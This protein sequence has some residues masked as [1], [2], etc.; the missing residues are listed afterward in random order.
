MV[1]AAALAFARRRGRAG[2]QAQGAP[3]RL[4]SGPGRVRS[5]ADADD[6]C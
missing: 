2:S 3:Q 6:T 4:Q 1:A 5:A